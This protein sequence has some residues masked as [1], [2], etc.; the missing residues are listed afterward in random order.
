MNERIILKMVIIG[1]V[2]ISCIFSYTLY[3]HPTKIIIQPLE[4]KDSTKLDIICDNTSKFVEMC[5]NY[6]YTNKGS[7]VDLHNIIEKSSESNEGL[8]FVSKI[9]ERS[10]TAG[11]N[12]YKNGVK[13]NAYKVSNSMCHEYMKVL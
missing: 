12:V 10:F 1:A 7:F 2:I 8:S 6:G 3:K 11:K 9:C 4:V 13:R 5:Y